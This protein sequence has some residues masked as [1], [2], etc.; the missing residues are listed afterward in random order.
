VFP[1]PGRGMPP[2]PGLAWLLRVC[3]ACRRGRFPR[4]R[5]ESCLNKRTIE[6]NGRV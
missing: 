3:R 2:R 5:V 4:L 1:R 6:G